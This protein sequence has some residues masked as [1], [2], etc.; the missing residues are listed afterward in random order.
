L[1]KEGAK[2]FEQ[3]IQGHKGAISMNQGVI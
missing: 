3:F 2:T 1:S